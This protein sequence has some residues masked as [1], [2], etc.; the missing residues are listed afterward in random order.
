MFSSARQR[1]TVVHQSI[2]SVAPQGSMYAETR[3][4]T[5]APLAASWRIA[6][7]KSQS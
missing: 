6:S 2:G 7:G 1:F 4:R 3:M 5:S